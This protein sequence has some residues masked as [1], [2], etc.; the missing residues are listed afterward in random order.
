MK[1]APAVG[2]KFNQ[3]GSVRQFAGNTF[4]CHIEPENPVF[5]KLLWAQQTL[6]KMHCA[7]KFAFLPAS[8]F[9]MTLFEGLCDQVRVPELWSSKLPL[10][11]PLPEATQKLQ[12][13]LAPVK[14]SE[15]Y[16]MV[17]DAVYNSPVGGTILHLLPADQQCQQ[18]LEQSRQQLSELTGIR[19][20]D[21]H[22]YRFHITLSYK[23]IELNEDDE[24]ELQQ[25]SR[26]INQHL[27][28]SFGQLSH[29]P[30]AFCRFSD[31]FAF[32]PLLYLNK[33]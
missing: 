26:R 16:I 2:Q 4:V 11:L 12:Q 25:V 7:H 28:E 27:S 18:A 33:Q 1:F 14:D 8:S 30:P 17:Y 19:H 10:D 32:E 5:E 6:Q 22:S 9:H 20:A 31:M 21:H 24:K 3:N 23:I 13:E 29:N 15:N